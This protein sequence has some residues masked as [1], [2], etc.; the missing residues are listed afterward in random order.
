ME[1]AHTGKHSCGVATS[2]P[3]MYGFN[4][5]DHAFSVFGSDQLRSED[6]IF[7]YSQFLPPP[8]PPWLSLQTL[9]RG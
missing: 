7:G 9:T 3:L 2:R 8:Y 1:P 4:L 5:I 6:F